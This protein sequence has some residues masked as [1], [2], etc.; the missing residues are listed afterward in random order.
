[1]LQRRMQLRMQSGRYFEG[2]EQFA[3][4]WSIHAKTPL[5]PA[6]TRA[7]YENKCPYPFRLF[8]SALSGADATYFTAIGNRYHLLTFSEFCEYFSAY[9]STMSVFLCVRCNSKLRQFPTVNYD[10]YHCF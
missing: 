4:E 7:L 10:I 5:F 1:M 8:P 6:Q 2:M 3:A 9:F